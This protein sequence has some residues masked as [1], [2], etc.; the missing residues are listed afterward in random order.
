MLYPIATLDGLDRSTQTDV[1]V[2]YAHAFVDAGAWMDEL[3]IMLAREV[4]TGNRLKAERRAAIASGSERPNINPALIIDL[5]PWPEPPVEIMDSRRPPAAR[6]LAALTYIDSLIP[7]EPSAENR[8]V[9]ALLPVSIAAPQGYLQLIT[10]LVTGQDLPSCSVRHRYIV[11][12]DRLAPFLLPLL[13]QS[14]DSTV[15][16]HDLDFSPERMLDELAA[17]VGDR[18]KPERERVLGVLQ[19]AAV[20]FSQQRYPD[21]LDKYAAVY[22]YFDGKDQPGLQAL[23]LSGAGDVAAR[24]GDHVT[25]LARHRQA[26]A[27]VAPTQQPALLLNP[28]LAAGKAALALQDYAEAEAY[29]GNAAE[30]AAKTFNYTARCDALLDKGVAQ[31]EA[32]KLAEALQTWTAGK[33]LAASFGFAE[34]QRQHLEAMAALYERAGMAAEAQQCRAELRSVS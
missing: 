31:R 25:A 6:L 33:T 2:T 30:L 23:C 15:L 16:V 22:D 27:L 13:E 34:G 9:C 26:L 4:E 1:F 18:S 5:E 28:M 7:G 32:G 29:L 24:Q 14:Q 12:D 11:R 8:L 20:D 17:G 19:L 21:A 3:A 10:G